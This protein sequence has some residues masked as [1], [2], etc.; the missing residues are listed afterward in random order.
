MAW[1]H[2]CATPSGYQRTD[3]C[4]PR[5]APRFTLGCDL[6]RLQRKNSLAN[7]GNSRA[8]LSR[9]SHLSHGSH[10]CRMCRVRRICRMVR[11]RRVRR[12]C[13]ADLACTRTRRKP[14]VL[15]C[16]SLA[17]EGSPGF[18]RSVCEERHALRARLAGGL[19]P[20]LTPTIC[21]EI[22]RRSPRKRLPPLKFRR[23]T[24]PT[25]LARH[26]GLKSR[27]SLTFR[28]SRAATCLI[29][30]RRTSKAR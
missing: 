7:E 8:L 30:W 23:A 18:I 29:E 4:G 17:C 9:S 16:R 20:P 26:G 22:R 13:R 24:L 3:D 6:Q 11:I 27:S 2:G 12:I 21:D 10:L 15:C 25:A 14:K 5:V 1:S 19:R 28:S